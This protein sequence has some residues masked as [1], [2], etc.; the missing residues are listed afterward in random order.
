MKQGQSEVVY[1][2][3]GDCSIELGAPKDG[4]IKLFL[5]EEEVADPS[6]AAKKIDNIFRITSYAR[7]RLTGG[8]GSQTPPATT[9]PEV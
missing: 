6:A 8:K 7:Q 4:R 3:T 5:T 2:T 9:Y 1:R